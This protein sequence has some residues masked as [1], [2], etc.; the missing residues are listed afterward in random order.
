MLLAG[1]LK[2]I[3]KTGNR[4]PVTLLVGEAGKKWLEPGNMK[5]ISAF[6]DGIGPDKNLL[7]Q[8]PSI[9]SRAREAGLT[10]TPY[11]FRKLSFPEQFSSVTEE[12]R[13]MLYT[14]GADALFTDNPDLFPRE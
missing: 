12:M 6:A 13:H 5:D 9:V 1:T 2:K 10:V 8:D 3:K 11:T 7:Y 4:H 14:L